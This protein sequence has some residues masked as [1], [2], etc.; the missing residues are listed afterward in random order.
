MQ[1]LNMTSFGVIAVSLDVGIIKVFVFRSLSAFASQFQHSCIRA[2]SNCFG[3]ASQARRC[4][5]A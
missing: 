1:A 3:Q 2:L 4:L 5:Y